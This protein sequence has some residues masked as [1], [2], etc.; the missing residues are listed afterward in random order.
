MND[1]EILSVKYLTTLIRKYK[2]EVFPITTMGLF[3]EKPM[4]GHQAVWDVI[5]ADR[6][7]AELS[8][9][10][11][12]SKPIDGD[13]VSQASAE[14]Y[15]A[16][17]NTVIDETALIGIRNPGSMELQTIGKDEVGRRSAKL[18]KKIDRMKEFLIS[19][20]LQ[21]TGSVKI[22]GKTVS[23]P[24]RI[25]ADHKFSGSDWT[26]ESVKIVEDI[27]ADLQKIEEDSG[28]TPMFALTS[29][30]CIT[31]I[32]QNETVGGFFNSTPAGVDYMVTGKLSRFKG[33]T[34]IAH[35][36][37]YKPTGGSPTR[38]IGEDKVIYLPGPDREIAELQ[39][40]SEAVPSADG[41]S[42]EEKIGRHSWSD[43]RKDPVE[44]VLYAVER[45]FP[46]IYQPACFGIRTWK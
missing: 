1:P 46:T 10:T 35:N 15:K 3:P 38:F 31:A 11:S 20:A 14:M 43:L 4:R 13:A 22:D 29:R 42:A 9:G 24:D 16:F 7:L 45:F 2:N 21:S 18:A 33:L 25:A 37:T 41:R 19:Q 17:F 12:G 32:M 23:L 6:A 28:E 34:W 39:V 8:G 5:E 40:G 36:Q 44:T 26:D 27:D 30:E